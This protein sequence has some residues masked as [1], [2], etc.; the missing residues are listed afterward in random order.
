MR[1][2]VYTYMLIYRLKQL[3]LYTY[4]TNYLICLYAYMLICLYA[5]I[6][7]YLYTYILKCVFAS[8]TRE[9]WEEVLKTSWRASPLEWIEI[10]GPYFVLEN[11]KRLRPTGPWS[12]KTNVLIC[13]YAYMLKYLICL[14]AYML[15]CLYAYMLIYII[16]L[17]YI[18]YLICLYAYMLKW[19]ENLYGYMLICLYV[20]MLIFLLSLYAYM[21][22]CLSSDP[23]Q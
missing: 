5:Y 17:I 20:Y 23:T 6:L 8:S 1:I 10:L 3:I 21:L 16:Y 22:I 9:S 2:C 18:V 14:Y 19:L 13:L 15:I 4:I 12:R 11:W 7:I